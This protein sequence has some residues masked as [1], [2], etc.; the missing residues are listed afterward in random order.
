MTRFSE[1]KGRQVVSTATADTV[2]TVSE[3]V[4]DPVTRSVLALQLRKAESGDTLRYTDITAFGADAVTV[5]GADRITEPGE[6][7]TALL[8]KDHQLVGKR[9]L[10]SAGDEIG[11]VGDVEFSPESG[12]LTTIHL[13][14]GEVGG[15]RLL[16]VGSYAVVVSAE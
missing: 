10:T 3:L 8:G 11:K 13:D 1:A 5:S 2:G 6:D 16:G 9:V 15:Q 14:D 4:V 12:R 7:V